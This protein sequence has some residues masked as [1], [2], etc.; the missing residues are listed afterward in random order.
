MKYIKYKESRKHGSF[1]FPFAFYSVTHQ[2]PR[3]HMLHHWHPEFELLRVVSG[4]LILQVDG[5]EITGNA[6]D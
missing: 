3:Y 1:D 4:S 5:L 2:H 6:G